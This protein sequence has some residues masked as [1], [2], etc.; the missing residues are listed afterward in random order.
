MDKRRIL[1]TCCP[2]A[3]VATSENRRQRMNKVRLGVPRREI[4]S[5]RLE[6]CSEAR[7]DPIAQ[8]AS[9]GR[10]RLT[11]H[12]L[13]M[14]GRRHLRGRSAVSVWGTV[15]GKMAM[16]TRCAALD[17]S[18]HYH[19]ISSV[20]P[21]IPPTPDS[22][23][24]GCVVSHHHNTRVHKYRRRDGCFDREDLRSVRFFHL[25]QNSSTGHLASKQQRVRHNRLRVLHLIQF[26]QGKVEG[27]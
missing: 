14:D 21:A 1:L 20:I 10:W 22:S 4:G 16:R 15:L 7:R 2:C 18:Q 24:D 27:Y 25:Q 3:H 17:C 26:A 13:K 9:A 8:K 6:K 23:D 19:F 12:F 5:I 11:R